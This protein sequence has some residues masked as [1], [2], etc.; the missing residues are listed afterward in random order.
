A[1]LLFLHP[2]RRLSRAALPAHPHD[3]ARR[4]LR[5]AW[6]RLEF[7]IAR[8][9]MDPLH[10]LDA[11]ACAAMAAGRAGTLQDAPYGLWQSARPLRRPRLGVLQ[12]RLVDLAARLAVRVDPDP[13]A[14]PL[15]GLQSGRVALV[16]VRHPLRR[17]AARIRSLRQRDV[18]PLLESDRLEH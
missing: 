5:H 2:I 7:C 12:A 14:F 8:R 10:R 9:A 13:A 16:G 3:L 17:G 1:V 15:W 4:A 11:R 18:R 6:L